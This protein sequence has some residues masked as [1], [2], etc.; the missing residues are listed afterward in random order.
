[1]R[2]HILSVLSLVGAGMVAATPMEGS[3]SAPVKRS[4]DS[5]Q[6]KVQEA[7]AAL[8]GNKIEDESETSDCVGSLLCCGSLTTPL[9]HIV[10]P[11]LEDLGIDVANIV[12]SIGLLCDPYEA[13]TCDSAPQCCTEANLL[14]GT[15]ALGCSALK[16]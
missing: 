9:D 6:T 10:D 16:Q 3:L 5:T 2:F 12:G 15:L 8:A 11:I 4:S 13:S 7:A 14:G 1:M